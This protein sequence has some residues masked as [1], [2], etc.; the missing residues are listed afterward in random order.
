MAKEHAAKINGSAT[1]AKANNPR[2]FSRGRFITIE[3]TIDNAIR[4]PEFRLITVNNF[5]SLPNI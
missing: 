3:K 2:P 5:V 4:A 1:I